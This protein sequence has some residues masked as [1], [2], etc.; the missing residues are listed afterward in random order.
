MLGA[1]LA[2]QASRKIS[3]RV[4]GIE[5][6]EGGLAVR[7]L[8]IQEGSPLAGE[9]LASAEVGLRTGATVIGVWRAGDFEPRPSAKTA[10]P[11]GGILI[12]VGSDQSLDRLAQIVAPL[13]E[14]GPFV[15]CGYGE[16]GQKVAQLL[17]DV[18]ET[19][20][21]I[22]L[23]DLPGV[24]RV[25]DV[26]D[27]RLLEGIGATSAQA[28]IVALDSDSATLFA[29]V[30][31]RDLAPQVP[32]IAPGQPGGVRPSHSSSRSRLRQVSESGLRP[33]DCPSFARGGVRLFGSASEGDEGRD[34]RLRGEASGGA[35]NPAKDSML[36]RGGDPGGSPDYRVR[37]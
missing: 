16:V 26:M 22:D 37:R 10:L 36:R 5:E 35:G 11:V 27:S 14:E 3:P 33:G 29:T 15:V 9:T 18:G 32:V 2:A 24:D 34:P 8:R 25:G 30:I 31:L 21:V 20:Q 19:V 6:L 1:A 12:A 4:S 23:Q 13:P 28:V 17:R 7:E